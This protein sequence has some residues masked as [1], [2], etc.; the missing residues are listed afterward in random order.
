MHLSIFA[1][2]ELSVVCESIF[3]DDRLHSRSKT[4]SWSW[5]CWSA[6]VRRKTNLSP[7]QRCGASSEIQ[8]ISSIRLNPKEASFNQAQSQVYYCSV[9]VMSPTPSIAGEKPV[10]TVTEPPVGDG[11]DMLAKA[12]TPDYPS[13][14]KRILIM[15]A[16]YLAA[17]LVTLVRN[18]PGRPK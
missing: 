6:L 18:F 5:C 1:R 2:L 3:E 16:L 7:E 4:E 11:K 12:K 17:F 13:N 9:L 10:V 8:R 15:A 14:Q